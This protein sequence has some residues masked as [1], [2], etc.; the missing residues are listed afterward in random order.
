MTEYPAPIRSLSQR[1]EA[2]E[3][4]N[5][6]RMY[7]AQL[8]RDIKAGTVSVRDV[9]KNPPDEILTMKVTDLLLAVPMVG[10][11]KANRALF[12]LRTSPSKTVGG[13]TVRQ[14]RELLDLVLLPYGQDRRAA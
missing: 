2:L 3:T 12:R 4:A 6:V 10:Q 7:R 1:R 8:K 11:T 9:L 5:R 14:R 13:L